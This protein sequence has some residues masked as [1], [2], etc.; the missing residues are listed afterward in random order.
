MAAT[1]LSKTYEAFGEEKSWG[2]WMKDSR[3]TVKP[4]TIRTRLASG[5]NFEE[6]ISAGATQPAIYEAFGEQKTVKDWMVDPRCLEPDLLWGRVQRGWD[7]QDALETGRVIQR[8]DAFGESKTLKEWSNDPR[9]HVCYSVLCDRIK[10]GIDILEALKP[11][12]KNN[13]FTIFGETKTLDEWILDSRCNVTREVF[14][15]RVYRGVDLESAITEGRTGIIEYEHDGETK[16]IPRWVLD[17]RCRVSVGTLR[18]RISGGGSFTES[19]E[20]PRKEAV[21]HE[22]FGKRLSLSEW[23][24]EPE[25]IVDSQATLHSR[26]Y[27]AGMSMEDALSVTVGSSESFKEKALANWLEEIG[28][29]VVRNNRTLI[30]PKELDI[31]LPDYNVAIEFNGLYWHSE[32]FKD[33]NYHYDKYLACKDK[34]IR[35]IQVWEDDWDYKE[36]I[37]KNMILHKLGIGSSE[38]IFARKTVIDRN[39]SR[40]EVVSLLEAN[41]IQGAASTS[42]SYGLRSNGNL[43]AVLC[44]KKVSGEDVEWDLV[45][46]ATAANVVGGFTKLLKAFRED[47]AGSIK[48]FADLTLSDGKL[49]ERTG[50]S[51]Q[52]IIKPD[53][54]YISTS[55]GVRQHKFN[56]RKERFESRDDLIFD[57][58]LTEAELARL[59]GLLRVYDAGKIK[60]ILN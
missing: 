58:E 19:I 38:R 17:G 41:H 56:Y 57:P 46:Y 32:K 5:K 23:V 8:F 48:T 25:C 2:D 6:A 39:P 44:M 7:F 1:K 35:L 50:F 27:K 18:R 55:S 33:K 12:D 51:L 28:L 15:A 37:V 40:A 45:R 47:Y 20:N 11:I 16:S 53:Y 10:D 34:G 26:I 60:Y 3:V 9:C 42:L 22:A 21:L 29:V 54:Y 24:N 49:Y 13:I 14:R 52:K 43:V 31:Y 4:R 30:A 59:N 36:L